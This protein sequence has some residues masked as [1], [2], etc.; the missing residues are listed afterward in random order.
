MTGVAVKLVRSICQPTI[1]GAAGPA[2]PCSPLGPCSPTSP[3]APRVRNDLPVRTRADTGC[4]ALG[5]K[6]SAVP[7]DDI[8]R[9]VFRI[10]A[11]GA[12]HRRRSRITPVTAKSW[13]LKFEVERADGQRQTRYRSFKGSRRAADLE[14]T[15]L[16]ARVQDGGHVEP[17]KIKVGDFVRTRIDLWA[18]AEQISARTRENNH[19]LCHRLIE[20]HLGGVL[21]QR[22]RT[23]HLEEWHAALRS[24]GVAARTVKQT[25]ALLGRVLRDAVRHGIITKNV[26]LEQRAPKVHKKDIRILT[27]DQLGQLPALLAGHVHELLALQWID[28]DLGRRELHVRR[29]LQQTRAFGIRFKKP[30]TSA[31]TRRITLPPI[32]VDLLRRH[33]QAQLEQRMRL[34]LGKAPDEALVFPAPNSDGQPWSPLDLSTRWYRFAR[35]HGLGVPFHSLRHTSASALIA[36]KVAITTVAHRLGHASPNVTLS[37]Y[38][39]LFH[40]DDTEAATA[41]GGLFGG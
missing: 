32:A 16:L 5:N 4:V 36:A 33:R 7:G 10:G 39:H 30:K 26:A 27:P 14:L 29:A 8:E 19:E 41:I 23:V 40:E 31:G 28:I 2:G 11:P 25:H 35:R 15:R 3:R 37:T 38:A 22:L 24:K 9:P 20:P 13:E 34:G 18:A 21:L 12:A 17:S 6:T 1:V